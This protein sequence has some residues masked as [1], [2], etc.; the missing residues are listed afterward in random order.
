M[1]IANRVKSIL[2]KGV[3]FMASLI[4]FN[5]NRLS[6]RPSGFEDFHN[7]IDDFFNEPWQ[8]MR[9]LLND[10]FKVD[11]IEKDGSYEIDA[12]LPGV[13][14]EEI[15]LDLNEGRLSISVSHEDVVEEEKRNY[16]HK[17]RRSTSM[18]RSIYL[19]DADRE[20]IKAKLEDGLLTITVGKKAREEKTNRIEIE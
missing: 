15:S 6:I 1:P 3:L 7:M 13:K 4:P 12:E 8:P 17:E 20:S 5:R 10:T 19:K 9:S 2:M 16:I 18:S 11:V 14:K